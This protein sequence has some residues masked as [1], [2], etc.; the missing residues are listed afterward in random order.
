MHG[1]L[2]IHGA[3]SQ[4]AFSEEPGYMTIAAPVPQRDN[5]WSE[6]LLVGMEVAGQ[7]K[8]AQL[9]VPGL[10]QEQV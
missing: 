8:V 4:R 6:G 1:C 2:C 9:Q 5:S 3:V 10:C 7:A